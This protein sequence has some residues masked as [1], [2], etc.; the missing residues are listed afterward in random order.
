MEVRDSRS[1][2]LFL[3]TGFDS[4]TNNNLSVDHSPLENPVCFGSCNNFDKFR[5]YSLLLGIFRVEDK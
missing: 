2:Q 1:V 5:N 3:L 4:F